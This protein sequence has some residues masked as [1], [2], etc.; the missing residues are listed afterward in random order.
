MISNTCDNWHL[1]EDRF[2]ILENLQVLVV[3]DNEDSLELVR[4]ILEDYKTQVVT[5]TSAREAFKVMKQS[6]GYR[7]APF[8]PD[9]LISDIA[10]P[11]EDGYW[12]IQQ[13]RTLSPNQ[14]GLIPAIALTAYAAKEEQIRSLAAGFHVHL[15]KPIE[16]DEL[17]AVV[18]HLAEQTF[19]IKVLN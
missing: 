15:P 17:V 3:D 16:P 6:T 9:V 14:G 2:K 18:A 13:I 1:E 8:K 5:V 7:K 10:M 12:L 19:G 11:F 4:I